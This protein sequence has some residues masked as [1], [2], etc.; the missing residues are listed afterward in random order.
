MIFEK[1]WE[2][3]KFIGSSMGGKKIDWL[4]YGEVRKFIGPRGR[5][6]AQNSVFS[7]AWYAVWEIS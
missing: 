6:L 7:T 3:G 5:F 1:E 2:R 4:E